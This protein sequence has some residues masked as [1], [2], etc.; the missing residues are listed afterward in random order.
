MISQ[1]TNIAPTKPHFGVPDE[2]R[3]LVMILSGPSGVG[4]D[5]ALDALEE[6][7]VDFHRVVTATSREPRPNE[8]DGQDYHFVKLSR[9][10]QMIENDELLEYALVYGDY[11]GVPK[12]EIV[13]PLARGQDVIMRVDVQGAAT[14][15]RK[16]PG[17]LT[18]FLTTAT[19]EEMVSRLRGR[20][21]DS[22]EQIAIRVAY[23]RK[24]LAELPKFQYAVVNHHD[25]L[26][27]TAKVLWAILE[28][29]RART[30]FRRV[31]IQ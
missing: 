7:G 13:E 31:I 30:D 15:A 5:S 12:S 9:F 6:L 26:E 25:S 27:K 4:K 2:P 17:A 1:A 14:M 29:A 3:P 11:K 28:A 22:E 20:K 21:T 18:V 23:A 24:E 10:A 8:V 16:L 19:E